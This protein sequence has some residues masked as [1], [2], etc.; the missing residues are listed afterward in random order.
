M[1][2]AEN[3]A[4][5]MQA[6][7]TEEDLD[8]MDKSVHTKLGHSNLSAHI[9]A[10]RYTRDFGEC[11]KLI[12]LLSDNMA[13]FDITKLDTDRL[14]MDGRFVGQ[15]WEV[16]LASTL[17]LSVR[18][19]TLEIAVAKAI[20]IDGVLGKVDP[21]VEVEV[22]EINTITMDFELGGQ[23]GTEEEG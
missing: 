21:G 14:K 1:A 20:L 10:P 16:T 15:E 23:N 22:A 2:Y 4:D 11:R 9:S 5:R 17:D 3:Y 18:G 6:Q 8:Q 7:Y 13:W 12:D 19:P